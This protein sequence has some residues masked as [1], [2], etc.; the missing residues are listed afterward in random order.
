MEEVAGE[1]RTVIFVSHNMGLIQALCERAYLLRHGRVVAEG[2]VRSVVSEYLGGLTA[3]VSVPVNERDDR[4]G[5]GSVKVTQLQVGS[6]EPDGVIRTGC[7]LKITLSYESSRPLD[8]SRFLISIYDT[9]R[10]GIYLL[11]SDSK[12][13]LPEVLPASGTL[14]CVTGPLAV[15]PGTCYVNFS[16]IRA[17]VPADFVD[18]VATFDV[19]SD[20]MH[21]LRRLPARDEAVAVV[22]QQWWV[23][24]GDALSA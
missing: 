1:G 24:D 4:R 19:A 14:N 20:Q 6:L 23:G 13:F 5:D 2:N 18:N 22:N 3:T 12:Q 7:R 21:G 11:E 17:G 9:T 8:R 16:V 15:T 10:T